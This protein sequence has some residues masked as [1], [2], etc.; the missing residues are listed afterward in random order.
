M[1]INNRPSISSD[2]GGSKPSYGFINTMDQNRQN[3]LNSVLNTSKGSASS[4]GG[5]KG[6]SYG[7]GSRY[8]GGGYGYG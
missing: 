8:S 2:G 3:V 5:N 1:A 6:T 4:G 7:G